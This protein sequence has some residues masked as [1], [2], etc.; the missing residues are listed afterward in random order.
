MTGLI[1][2]EFEELLI[3]FEKAWDKQEAA[4]IESCERERGY[5]GRSQIRSGKK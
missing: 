2:S 5:G 4:H 3:A 1:R